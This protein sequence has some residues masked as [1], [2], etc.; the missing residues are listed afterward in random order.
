MTKNELTESKAQKIRTLFTKQKKLMGTYFKAVDFKE[1]FAILIRNNGELDLYEE[2]TKGEFK[3][4]HSNGEERS[5]ILVPSK[6]VRMTFLDRATKG[7]IL[8]ED[9]PLPL[10]EN[11]ILTV[12]MLNITIEKTLND[13]RKWKA[14]ELQAKGDFVK[15]FPVTIEVCCCCYW[16]WCWNK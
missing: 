11:P 13:I 4:T 14:E 2:A 12:E 10:P 9:N 7:Y 6:Q 16:V 15:S 3:F 8:H 5:I 1:P